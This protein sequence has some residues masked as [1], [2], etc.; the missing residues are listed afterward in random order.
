MNFAIG[1]KD[2]QTHFLCVNFILFH[3]LY[4]LM[5]LNYVVSPY[6]ILREPDGLEIINLKVSLSSFKCDSLKTYMPI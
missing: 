1:H 4:H 6:P 3:D 2:F 5:T